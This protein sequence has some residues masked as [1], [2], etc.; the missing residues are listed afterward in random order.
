MLIF[1]T[2]SIFCQNTKKDIYPIEELQVINF[3]LLPVLDT[4]IQM[5]E[6]IQWYKGTLFFII[7]FDEDSIKPD[8]V[9]VR[10]YE[11]IFYHDPNFIGFFNY[12]E[13][14]FV[15][16][17]NTIDTTIFQKIGK[18]HNF[19]IG[20][21]PIRYSKNG[22]PI[23]GQFNAF[24][25]WSVRYKMGKFTILGFCTH[26]KNHPWFNNIDKEYDGKY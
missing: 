1:L 7:E 13:H 6:E 19:D 9:F 4:I 21:P 24:A 3:N 5:K 11:K 26:D 14:F 20:F 12:K 16:K 15:I 2:F 25:V 22:E 18:N 23:L 10:A 17:G 8:L